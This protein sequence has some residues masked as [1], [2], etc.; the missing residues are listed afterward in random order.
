MKC[1]LLEKSSFE[2]LK[3]II[4]TKTNYGQKR[5]GSDCELLTIVK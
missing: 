1:I 2:H 4:Y 5:K 3:Q